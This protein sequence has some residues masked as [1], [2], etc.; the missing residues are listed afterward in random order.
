MVL[1]GKKE[2]INEIINKMPSQPLLNKF[3]KNE[4]NLKF[5]DAGSQYGFTETSFSNGAAYGDLDNDGDLDLIVNNINAP[6]FIYKNNTNEIETNNYI[7]FFLQG[8]GNNTFAIGSTIKIYQGSQVISREIMPSRGFQSSVDYKQIIGL[9]KGIADSI[10]II[11]PDRSFIKMHTASINTVH[12][13]RQS[14]TKTNTFFENSNSTVEPLLQPIKNNF[15][16]HNENEY[17]D[18]YFERNIPMLIS[19]EGPKAA[20]GDVNGDGLADVYIA[21][22]AKQPGQLYLQNPHGIFIKKEVKAFEL[23]ANFE[24]VATLFFDCDKDGDL[25]L[26]AGSGGNHLPPK[27]REVQNRLYKNDGKGNFE[28]DA[29][30]LPVNDH[31]TGVVIA[32]DIDNDG[33]QDLFVAGRSV[34]FN[35]GSSPASYIL[36]NDGTGKFIDI[37]HTKNKDIAGIGM[38]TGAVWANVSGDIQKEL[39]IAGEWMTPRIFSFNKDHFEEV[40]TNLSHVYGWWKTVSAADL[41]NDG[42]QD[43]VLGNI[44]ENFYLSPDSLHPVKMF[45]HDFDANGSLEKILTRTINGKDMPVFLK[46]DITDQI[47]SLKKQNLKH[48]DYAKKTIQDLFAADLIK[49]CLVKQFNY[50]SSCIAFNDGKGNFSIKKL[51]LAAQLSSI[52]AVLCTDVNKDGFTDI[53]A[54]G[55]EFG[56]LPQFCRIDASYGHVM[57]ND[58]KG[59]FYNMSSDKS[60]LELRGQIRDISQISQKNDKY[61]LIL[62]NNEYPALYKI[63]NAIKKQ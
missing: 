25:D 29:Y 20:C 44:G 10:V 13:I 46:R 43:L 30:A 35:Y 45:I 62:Q 28:I 15:E 24:D 34:S 55:N 7:G 50:N 12:T 41:D 1:T 60:G 63:S 49:K 37:A 3:F 16:K 6:A 27:S 21:G 42:D 54:G 52:N 26:F 23:F 8:N 33:D 17:T 57:L 19:R 38:V 18:F 22:A 11:W 51:P 36:I 58:G 53:I 5:S 61:I 31:N 47:P 14:Q 59:N 56:F 2:D 4:G 39:I 32:N 9:G 40:K 48:Q